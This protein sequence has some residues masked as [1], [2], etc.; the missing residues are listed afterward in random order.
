MGWSLVC[1]G[2]VGVQAEFRNSRIGIGAL[3]LI[4][5]VDADEN[6]GNVYGRFHS[7]QTAHEKLEKGGCTDTQIP[8]S[9][10]RLT[11]SLL[12]RLSQGYIPPTERVGR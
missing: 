10:S 8:L 12:T 6:L 4:A 7:G 11:V 1:A 2:R 5:R 9:D 3:V